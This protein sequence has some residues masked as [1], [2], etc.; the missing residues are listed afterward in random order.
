MTFPKAGK[1]ILL[2]D[3]TGMPDERGAMG[4]G[5]ALVE[6]MVHHV[7]ARGLKGVPLGPFTSVRLR[8]SPEWQDVLK[9]PF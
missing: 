6:H 7:R 3:H 2:I 5:K 4:V 9:D 8:K 1:T